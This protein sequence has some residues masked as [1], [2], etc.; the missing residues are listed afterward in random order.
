MVKIGRMRRYALRRPG[1][2]AMLYFFIGVV[3]I[4]IITLLYSHLII[5][6]V[7]AEVKR[8][9]S[10]YATLSTL[11]I[12]SRIP[13]V[14]EML[15][16][17]IGETINF[18]TIITDKTG[19][20]IA[21]K[22]TKVELKPDDPA[23]MRELKRIME[24][25]DK[26]N[27]PIPIYSYHM[28]PNTKEIEKNLMFYFHY[29]EPHLITLLLWL[30]I[31]EIVIIV[32]FLFLGIMSYNN[33]RRSE[34]E[35]LWAG[36][37]KETAHQIGTP[38][39]SLIGW[40]E[41]L[42]EIEIKKL[43]V[44]DRTMV[45]KALSEIENDIRR[46]KR[47]STRFGSIGEKPNLKKQNLSTVVK[48]AI[49]YSKKRF[50]LDREGISLE[51]RYEEDIFI[52]LNEEQIS[53]CIENLVKNSVFA[54]EKSKKK[55]ITI[56]VKRINQTAVISIRDTGSGIEKSIRRHI[57]NPGFT[58]KRYGWGFGLS[59]VKRIVEEFHNGRIKV[60]SKVGEG[61]EFVILIPT[62]PIK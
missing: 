46:L 51:E 42:K 37:A 40:L 9:S 57:F 36:M 20:I 7:R 6:Q 54:L 14:S 5:N 24:E 44:K 19:E 11:L 28:N 43:R 61:T 33:M 13:Q 34:R 27:D 21:A 41:I 15:A 32:L 45:E 17:E 16:E 47:I 49:D 56:T 22:N 35:A 38:V 50:K 48:K 52:P 1:S 18:P 4:G 60:N 31:L 10:A 26:S 8:T 30:P 3:I 29:K 58:T 39:S 25:M 23:S 12:S 53:W 2:M 59:L 55:S 62:K